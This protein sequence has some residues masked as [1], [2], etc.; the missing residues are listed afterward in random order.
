MRLTAKLNRPLS[1]MAITNMKSVML[2]EEGKSAGAETNIPAE[3]AD[4]SKKKPPARLRILYFHEH[5]KHGVLLQSLSRTQRAHL[6]DSVARTI[7]RFAA[8]SRASKTTAY[9]FPPKSAHWYDAVADSSI[10]T[11]RTFA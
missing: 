7:T 4:K 6:I 3:V 1:H 8:R 9:P 2:E 5:N 11:F 10:L